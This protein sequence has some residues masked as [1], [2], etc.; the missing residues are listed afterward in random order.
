MDRVGWGKMGSGRVRWGLMI[1]GE[2]RRGYQIK[3]D[4][5]GSGGVLWV[6]LDGT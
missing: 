2:V 1:L 3:Q 5:V 4:P 6:E